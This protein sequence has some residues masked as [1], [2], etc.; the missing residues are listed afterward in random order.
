MIRPKYLCNDCIHKNICKHVEDMTNLIEWINEKCDYFTNDIPINLSH[1]TC[2]YL[3]T[4]SEG[5]T[6]R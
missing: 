3:T 2:D 1:I 6:I 4:K 5:G